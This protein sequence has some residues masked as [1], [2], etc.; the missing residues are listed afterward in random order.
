MRGQTTEIYINNQSPQI[1]LCGP[2]CYLII[3][4]IQLC[5]TR[6]FYKFASFFHAYQLFDFPISNTVSVITPTIFLKHFLLQFYCDQIK[7]KIV[8][9][10]TC[11]STL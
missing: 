2:N 10:V 9:K 5:L 7:D 6:N 4:V 8:D 1:H 3:K 11:F